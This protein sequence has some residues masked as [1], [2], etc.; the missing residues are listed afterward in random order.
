[1]AG[2][3]AVGRIGILWRG[4]AGAPPPTRETSRFRR[5]FDALEACQVAG[6]PV[7]YADDVVDEVRKRLLGLDGVLIWVDPIVNGQ[8]R[9]RLDAM[10]R[11]VASEGVWVSAHPDVI[12]RMGTKDVLYR[13][14]HLGWGTD[15]RLYRTIDELRESLPALLAAGPRV[16]KQLR[17]NGGNGVWKVELVSNA[18]PATEATVRVLHALRGSAIEETRLSDF[19]QSCRPYFERSGGM[20]DQPFQARLGEGM[21]RCYLVHNRVVGFGFQLVKALM[22]PPHPEAGPEAAEVPPRLYYGPSK[23]E[24]QVLKTKLESAWVLGMQQVLSIETESLPAI[25]DAD[26]LYG[27]KTASG[28]D[29]YV[30]C[31]INVQSVYPFPEEALEPLAQASVAGMLAAKNMRRR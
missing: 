29:T 13:T 20:V 30:L 21:I 6:E 16:L 9:S 11:E 19:I 10:L 3:T 25:W 27:P 2:G 24:F 7:V 14:R 15:T 26:F 5:V 22:P 31:E 23:P 17:G 8:D 28:E 4:D 1:M 12:P 18:S